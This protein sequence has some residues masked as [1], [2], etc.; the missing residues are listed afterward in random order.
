MQIGW[1][2]AAPDDP[3]TD[4]PPEFSAGL[5]LEDA[6]WGES[7]GIRSVWALP[8][9]IQRLWTRGEPSPW[10]IAQKA[11]ALSARG[12]IVQPL[13]EPNL[14]HLG[15]PAD[16]EGWP[17]GAREHARW[18]TDVLDGGSDRCVWMTPFS[19]HPACDPNGWLDAALDEL[20]NSPRA[21]GGSGHLPGGILAH[22][23]GAP[24]QVES[25]VRHLASAASGYGLP[26]IVSEL[27]PRSDQ[28]LE[29]WLPQVAECLDVCAGY[30]ARAA[31]VFAPR[32]PSP[33]PGHPVREFVGTSIENAMRWWARDRA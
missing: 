30:G 12:W 7:R 1:S 6:E 26:W 19:P 24:S 29:D 16:V 27:G 10:Q 22:A 13:N 21:H 9:R 31:L 32:W 15:L 14:N 28:T 11:S 8:T 2:H 33:D 4:C 25:A 5:A 23:Y 20:F 18:L 3:A 17:G